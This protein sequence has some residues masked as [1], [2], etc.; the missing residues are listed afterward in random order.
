M[1]KRDKMIFNIRKDKK[2]SNFSLVSFDE[3]IYVEFND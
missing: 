1:D 3:K 2:N